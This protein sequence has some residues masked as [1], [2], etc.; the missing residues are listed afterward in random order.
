MWKRRQPRAEDPWVS[1][2]PRPKDDVPQPPTARVE[3]STYEDHWYEV[4]RRSRGQERK[5]E[6]G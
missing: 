2:A 3:K 5:A 6:E 1:T 4:L